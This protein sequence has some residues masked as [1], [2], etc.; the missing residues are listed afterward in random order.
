MTTAI[1]GGT[2]FADL[3]ADMRPVGS[4]DTPYGRASGAWTA[5]PCWPGAL[6]LNR[7]GA[8]GTRYLPH[9]VNYRANMW[10]ARQ[11]GANRVLAVYAV[12]GI[13]R[14]LEVGE[15][16]LPHQL[17]DYTW[18]RAHTFATGARPLH[19][20]FAEPFDAG[21]RQALDAAAADA[22]VP[23]RRGA[24]YGCAQGPRLETIAEIE[25]MAADGCDVVGM[26]AMPEVALARELELP[27]GGVCLVVNPAAGRA[28][29]GRTIVDLDG[30]VRAGRPRLERV[31]KAC[32]AR[33][34][35]T[36]S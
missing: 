30:V 31:L 33:L 21:V 8:D 12:G 13:A 7:H 16:V 2:G 17:I 18:G 1:I 36:G 22:G 28:P 11:H 25:R 29:P 19:V 24:V 5:S 9:E 27:L 6:F 32:C 4:A 34:S 14:D 20:D 3:G 26:T 15:L 10:L 35:G 23:A